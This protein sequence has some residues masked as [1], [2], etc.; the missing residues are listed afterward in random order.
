MTILATTARSL[1]LDDN[2][3]PCGRCGFVIVRRYAPRD[4]LC[5][6]C[7]QV[8]H[9]TVAPRDRTR[10]VVNGVEV[11]CHPWHGDFD[12]E[13]NPMRFGRLYLPGPRSCGHRDCVARA[14]IITE[15]ADV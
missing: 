7:R 4:G 5:V 6:D 9:D 3:W 15:A 8:T 14:H 1:G 13:D 10:H 12:E 11:T 2:E